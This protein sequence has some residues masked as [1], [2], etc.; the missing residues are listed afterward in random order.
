MDT[1]AT[2]AAA[3]KIAKP[4]KTAKVSHAKPQE[5]TALPLPTPALPE[6]GQMAVNSITV[7][8]QVRKD[9]DDGELCGTEKDDTWLDNGDTCPK[10]KLVQ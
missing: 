1:T 6:F 7:L 8:E 10:C 3:A 5:Q 9:F 2:S 4:K